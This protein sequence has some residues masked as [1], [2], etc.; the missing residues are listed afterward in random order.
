MMIKERDFTDGKDGKL[1]KLLLPTLLEVIVLYG[2][3]MPDDFRAFLWKKIK[4]SGTF[5]K[6]W[7]DF[8]YKYDYK[9]D[10]GLMQSVKYVQTHFKKAG[11]IILRALARYYMEIY[12][13]GEA[14]IW[15]ELFALF[16]GKS[17]AIL[18]ETVFREYGM[19]I[20]PSIWELYQSSVTEDETKE[21]MILTMHRALKE[22]N[23]R[24]NGDVE[25]VVWFLVEKKQ[26]RLNPLNC[27]RLPR[28]HPSYQR[29]APR[30]KGKF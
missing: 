6:C 17:R 30:R 21:T 16:A 18:E 2:D 1:K 8:R 4:A 24:K 12:G 29:L 26:L 23:R 28:R 14:D 15:K 25:N 22:K 5:V 7:F 10:K 19:G 9:C 20:N 11:N 27:L 13:F 3:C